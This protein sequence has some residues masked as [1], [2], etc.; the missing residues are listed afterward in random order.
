M[1]LI[2]YTLQGLTREAGFEALPVPVLSDCISNP[3][4]LEDL[5][6]VFFFAGLACGLLLGP[7]VDLLWLV[8]ERWRRFI[9]ARIAQLQPQPP[10]WK[11]P[12]A[13]GP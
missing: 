9:F 12:I 13:Q 10:G 4:N 11:S 2:F 6:W 8:K 7:I 3:P 1:H 5:P